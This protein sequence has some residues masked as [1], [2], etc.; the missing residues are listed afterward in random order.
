MFNLK[1]FQLDPTKHKGSQRVATR[2]GYSY[3]WSLINGQY[4][5]SEFM[6]SPFVEI[7]IIGNF[8]WDNYLKY[9]GSR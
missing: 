4:G 7:N 3:D 1:E 6:I 9:L 5:L 8:S 2:L